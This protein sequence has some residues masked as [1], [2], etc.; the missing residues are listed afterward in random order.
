VLRDDRR[1]LT[2]GEIEFRLWFGPLPVRWLAV[3][4]PGPTPHSFVD[5][6]VE[7][8]LASW[9]HAHMFEEVDGGILLSDRIT[10]AHKSG[11]PGLFTRL[12]FDGWPLRL[13]F[14]YRH[15]RT[16]LALRAR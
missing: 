7:G 9:E 1:S 15:W 13:L 2:E 11:V 6:M 16:R 4:L 5:R 3:H 14:V 12:I 10:L 8:P